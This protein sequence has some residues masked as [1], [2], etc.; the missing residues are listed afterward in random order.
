MKVLFL[1]QHFKTPYRG[2]AIR[3]YYLAK[4][5]V[6]NGHEVVV[7]TGHNDDYKIE[8]V[9][10]ISVHYLKVPYENG[11]GFLFRSISFLRY[12]WLAIREAKLVKR[13]DLCYA[14]SVPLTVGIAARRIQKR[15]QI[16]YVFEVG[17]LWPDAPVQMGIVSNYFLKRLLYAMELKIYQSANSIVA[18]SPSIREVIR[19]RVPGKEVHLL[20]N[21]ADTDFFDKSVKDPS[22]QI[23][24]EVQNKFVVSY[25]GAIGAANGL[26]YLIGC[27]DASR[28][29]GLPIHFIL[30]G[31]GAHK[32]KLKKTIS[33]LQLLNV[34]LF[35]FTNRDGVEEIMNVTDAAFICYKPLSILETGSPNK[36]F[37]ALAS[38]KMV[39]I[40]FGGWIK[41]EIEENNCG[42][43]VDP[44]QPVDFVK[45]IKPILI[46]RILLENYQFNARS[47]AEKKYS[48]SELSNKFCDIIKTS[49]KS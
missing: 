2:G 16:P 4:A 44:H 3:S 23:K 35:E 7:I 45:K 25:I 34:T 31:E 22:L 39:V 15:Y 30:C 48:R 9:D 43:Y 6:D 1:H 14:I 5:L 12:V 47:L 37:D 49:Q 21:M 17:D 13:V 11:F 41:E 42:I 28:K 20:P 26:D 18:L 10:G 29:A 46:D 40:N 19:E 38:G 24:Y 32:K 27:A 8:D 36:F 33:D